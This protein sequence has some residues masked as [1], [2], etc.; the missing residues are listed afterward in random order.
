MTEQEQIETTV[1]YP[2]IEELL[3]RIQCDE[4]TRLKQFL[5]DL[6]FTDVLDESPQ[7]AE[8]LQKQIQVEAAK[9]VDPLKVANAPKLNED[10]SNYFVI[11]NLPKCEEAKVS[12]LKGLIMKTTTKQNLNVTEENIDIP[13]DPATNQTYGVAFI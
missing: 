4:L 3:A 9:F 12:K 7:L 6:D 5:P 8:Y 10:F 2:P 13:V 1:E 11:N